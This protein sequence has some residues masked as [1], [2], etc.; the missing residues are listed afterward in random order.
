MSVINKKTLSKTRRASYRDTSRT[1]CFDERWIETH[2]EHSIIEEH[3]SLTSITEKSFEENQRFIFYNIFDRHSLSLSRAQN[4]MKKKILFVCRIS[5]M[6]IWQTTHWWI[7]VRIWKIVFRFIV[8]NYHVNAETK[9]LRTLWALSIKE[10]FRRHDEHRIETH[11]EHHVLTN[12]ESKHIENI[13]S[14]KNAL[15]LTSITEK[16]FEENQRFIFYNIFDRRSMS[17]SRAHDD[18]KKKNFICMSNF[19]ND[20]LTNDTLMNSCRTW[21]IMFRFIATSYHVN[22]ETKRLKTLWTLSI[23]EHFRRHDEHYIE[24]HREH[25][26]LTNV[27]SKHIE[28]IQS[29]KSAH[30]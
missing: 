28:N 3:T 5:K 9:R 11:R 8:T 19:K 25:H 22:A 10:H 6:M 15:S 13:Q 14:S 12:V 4:D 18:M 26:V 30:F 29:S 21:K 20:D 2:R 27:E 24:T 17:L 7:F 16:L 1:S 23:K